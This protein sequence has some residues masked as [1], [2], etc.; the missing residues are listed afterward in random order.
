MQFRLSE[1]TCLPSRPCGPGG[2]T[3]PGS[4]LDS[5]GPSAPA[6]PIHRHFSILNKLLDIYNN[7]RHFLTS[8]FLLP[9]EIEFS[10][11]PNSIHYNIVILDT[12]N[13]CFPNNLVP[14]NK[15]SRDKITTDKINPIGM[16]IL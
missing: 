13:N 14:K 2:P 3:T 1:H 7:D 4:P 12:T 5:V 15:P 10:E 8:M 16:T 6:G 9:C 11:I